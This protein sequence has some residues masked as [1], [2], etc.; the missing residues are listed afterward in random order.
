MNK[1][2]SELIKLGHEKPELREHIRPV[3]DKLATEKT[4]ASAMMARELMNNA[5]DFKNILRRTRKD[6]RR[7][8]D[9]LLDINDHF[10]NKFTPN[11][12]QAYNR[13]RNVMN[14]VDSMDQDDLVN[15]VEKICDL[16]GIQ[17]LMT[18]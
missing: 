15:Q 11:E 10:S 14:R 7:V 16:L 9:M 6:N 18:F 2:A 5:G 12:E 13:L 1:L 8:Y 17:R 4:A 3:L